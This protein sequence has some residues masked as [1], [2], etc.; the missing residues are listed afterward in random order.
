[1]SVQDPATEAARLLS[2]IRQ[3]TARVD[4]LLVQ[5]R[6]AGM[7]WADLAAL[8]DPDDPPARS[9]AQRRIDSARRRLANRP[10]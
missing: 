6:D 5:L 3:M 10:D 9:S 7:S 2:Q 8:I 1:M 4:E